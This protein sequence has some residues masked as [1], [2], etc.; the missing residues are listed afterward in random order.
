MAKDPSEVRF[1]LE[2]LAR[3]LDLLLFRV[4]QAREHATWEADRQRTRREL[5][6]LRDAL[7]GLARELPDA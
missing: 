6:R 7:E 1:A 3:D 5:E 2:D 4:E